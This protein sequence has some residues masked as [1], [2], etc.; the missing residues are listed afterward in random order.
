M[1]LLRSLPARS[2]NRAR[3][4][5]VYRMWTSILLNPRK[6]SHSEEREFNTVNSAVEDLLTMGQIEDNQF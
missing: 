5:G 2:P 3:Q 1:G 4:A 6:E